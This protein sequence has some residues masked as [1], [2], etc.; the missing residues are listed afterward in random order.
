MLREIN[1]N[2]KIKMLY[3]HGIII[4]SHNE[5]YIMERKERMIQLF[6]EPVGTGRGDC[7]LMFDGIKAY[8]Q[9]QGF[10]LYHDSRLQ[11]E[12][13]IAGMVFDLNFIECN[14]MEISDQLNRCA[15]D[16]SV[17]LE[18][19]VRLRSSKTIKH[20][21]PEMINR[22]ADYCKE[23]NWEVKFDVWSLQINI[24]KAFDQAKADDILG[25]GGRKLKE[26]LEM[27]Q[28]VNCAKL[29]ADGE[30]WTVKDQYISAIIDTENKKIALTTTLFGKEY[31]LNT[32]EEFRS[33]V[34]DRMFVQECLLVGHGADVFEVLNGV[35][36]SDAIKLI[37]SLLEKNF[38]LDNWDPNG[39]T[40]EFSWIEGA[41]LDIEQIVRWC[42]NPPKTIRHGY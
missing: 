13:V 21:P 4:C 6:K 22:V 19:D 38:A 23:Q 29:S 24:N 8:L 42:D 15:D 30:T 3:K 2:L 39:G 16:E 28:N 31:T 7:Y 25:Y 11:P 17:S 26:F 1:T 34:A 18:L 14:T 37:E 5:K 33:Y 27:A 41:K 32:D 20:Y 12:I 36:N 35:K 40:V 10:S 9:L